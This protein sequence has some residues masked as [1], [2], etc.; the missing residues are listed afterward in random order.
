MKIWLDDVRQPPDDTWV[1]VKES[2]AAVSLLRYTEKEIEAVSLDHDLG[3]YDTGVPVAEYLGRMVSAPYR[4]TA[5]YI[6]SMN[7]VGVQRLLAALGNPPW[8]GIASIEVVHPRGIANAA[9]AE[10][11]ED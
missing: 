11:H 9:A 5:V 1:W 4:K 10:S 6:H 3:L 2:E 8:H 7:P